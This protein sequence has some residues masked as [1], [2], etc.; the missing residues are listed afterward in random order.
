MIKKAF[1]RILLY[2]SLFFILAAY[3]FVFVEVG[4]I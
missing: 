1:M 4:I 2:S 3:Y